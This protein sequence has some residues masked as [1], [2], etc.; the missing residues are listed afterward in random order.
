MAKLLALQAGARVSSSPDHRK[1]IRQSPHLSAKS[2][3]SAG[4]DM[5]SGSQPPKPTGNRLT[6]ADAVVV[7][8]TPEETKARQRVEARKRK[9][10]Q[11]GPEGGKAGKQ[12]S[13]TNSDCDL[14]LVQ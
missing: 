12:A 3:K 6:F 14:L 7:A 2:D 10:K 11:K 8:P 5:K 1:G 4:S 9:N 13:R